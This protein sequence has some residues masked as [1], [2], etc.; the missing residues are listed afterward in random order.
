MHGAGTTGTAG[1]TRPSLRD[2]LHAYVALSSVSGLLATVTQR[3]I[4][5]AGLGASI[6]APGPRNFASAPQRSS[7]AAFR[8]H[9]SPPHVS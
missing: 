6:G 7:H 8:G 5:P 3:I 9:R 4:I 2:G 1:Q